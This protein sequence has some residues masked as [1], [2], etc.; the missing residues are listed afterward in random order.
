MLDVEGLQP[1]ISPSPE[2][3]RFWAALREH[4]L[5]LPHCDSC[6]LTF[7]YPRVLCPGC[8]ARGL[9]WVVSQ[10]SGTL[11]SFCVQFGST[12]PGL[13]AGPFA[14]ALVD[15][16]DG[17]RVLGFLVGVPGD[18]ELIRCGTRVEVE[19][20]DLEDGEAVVAFRPAAEET[21]ES[22]TER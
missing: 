15:L 20:V 5:E 2:G 8:G 14:T 22:P 7:F 1:V 19:F 9:S 12:V 4:R 11:Y 18:P 21:G 17:P 16:D 3:R 6:G 10:G 13:G